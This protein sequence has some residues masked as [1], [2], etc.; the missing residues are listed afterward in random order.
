MPGS[1][2]EIPGL[3]LFF[4]PWYLD[5]VC[6]GGRWEMAQVNRAGRTAAVWP[7]F[8]KEKWGQRYVTMPPLC[9]MMGPY[10]HPDDRGTKHEPQILEALMDQLPLSMLQAF[11]QDCHHQLENWLPMYWRGF[12]QTTRYSYVLTNTGNI[13]DTFKDLAPDYRNNKLPKAQQR[14]VLESTDNLED[15]LAVHNGS[16]LRQGI[17]PPIESTLLRRLDEAL[18]VRNRRRIVWAL[19]RDDGVPHAA[20]YLA[21]DD[22]SAWLLLAG[23][24]PERRRSGAGILVTWETIRFAFQDL[25]LAEFNFAGSMIRSVERVRRQF[26]AVQHPYFRIEKEWSFIWK[27][28]KRMLR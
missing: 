20:A 22:V 3:P 21:W 5:A 17:K 18:Q 1:P 16:Y 9:R 2:I 13:D 11:A 28:G 7:Y 19:D 23:E 12:R 8:V 26:G 24:H 27:V 4:Y 6:V 15:F 10:L 14:V 25:G